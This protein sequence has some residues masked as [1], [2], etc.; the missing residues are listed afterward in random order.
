MISET[1]FQQ[2]L[3]INGNNYIII[4]HNLSL[5]SILSIYPDLAECKRGNSNLVIKVMRLLQILEHTI[6]M[7]VKCDVEKGRET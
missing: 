6:P 7:E 2:L 4:F 3:I 5:P 1:P